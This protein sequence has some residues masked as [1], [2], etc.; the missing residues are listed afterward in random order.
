MLPYSFFMYAASA[1]TSLYILATWEDQYYLVF[2][3]Y[4]EFYIHRGFTPSLVSQS[5]SM[6]FS[7]KVAETQRKYVVFNW[8]EL[9]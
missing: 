7:F 5:W 6:I 1:V 8:N 3:Q 9:K 2:D 4:N